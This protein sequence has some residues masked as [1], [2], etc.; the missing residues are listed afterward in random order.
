[1]PVLLRLPIRPRAYSD[2]SMLFYIW[3]AKL[4]IFFQF[5]KN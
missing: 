1:M 2:R 3:V 5:V 4:Q